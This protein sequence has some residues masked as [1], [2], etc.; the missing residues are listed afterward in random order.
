[1][2][3]D[4]YLDWKNWSSE[5]FGQFNAEEAAYYAAE[6]GI[7]AEA[8]RRVLEIGF[9]NGPML[10]WLRGTGAEVFGVEPNPHLV[11]LARKL[12]GDDHACG[13]LSDPALRRL[14]GSFTHVIA[15]DVLEHVPQESLGRML[16]EM[17][18]LLAPEGRIIARFPNGD[19]PFG[20]IHQH[21]DPTH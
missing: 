15:I 1:N 7:A 14:A 19:S 21:G 10:G 11:T 9:G 20:R 2:F 12:L 13:E 3:G 17:G 5:S 4:L 16:A 6:T 18:A 8:S